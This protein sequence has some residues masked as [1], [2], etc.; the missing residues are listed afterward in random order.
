MKLNRYSVG[1]DVWEET[2]AQRVTLTYLG[3]RPLA[4]KSWR[5]WKRS[6]LCRTGNPVS[7]R[8]GKPIF[9]GNPAITY[10]L[11]NFSVT[12]MGMLGCTIK[13]FTG[14]KTHIEEVGTHEETK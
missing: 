9:R 12:S 7:I 13:G 6:D 14:I 2:E 11:I 1:G 10:I 5:V 8:E 4:V 3:V